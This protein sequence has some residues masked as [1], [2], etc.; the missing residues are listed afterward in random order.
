MKDFFKKVSVLTVLCM[1]CGFALQA[2]DEFVVVEN[3]QAKCTIVVPSTQGK[4]MKWAKA[5]ASFVKASSKADLAIKSGSADGAV[6]KLQIDPAKHSDIEEFSFTF[7]DKNTIVISGG[8]ENGLKYGVFR[9][10]ENYV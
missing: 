10:L 3:H 1:A 8:S 9:F 6:I 4:F 7:P 5:L 2:A